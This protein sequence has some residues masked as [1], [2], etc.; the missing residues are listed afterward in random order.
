MATKKTQAKKA[1]RT[2]KPLAKTAVVKQKQPDAARLDKLVERIIA[3]HANAERTGQSA[4]I[5]EVQA[6]KDSRNCLK[7]GLK[8]GKFMLQAK[9]LV[10]KKKVKF[11]D[12]IEDECHI[13]KRQAQQ[14]MRLACHKSR[15]IESGVTSINAALRLLDEE[16]R[17]MRFQEAPSV[18]HQRLPCQAV[19]FLFISSR[20]PRQPGRGRSGPWFPS[21]RPPGPPGR[22][23]SHG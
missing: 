22:Q 10:K 23:Q 17:P 4:L 19:V 1:A 12:W 2:K 14:Y 15:V 21:P 20:R 18:A 8:V 13:G 7:S 6:A 3:E 5:H 9:P 16:N 11:I